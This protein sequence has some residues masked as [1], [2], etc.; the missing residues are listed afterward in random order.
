M[1]GIVEQINFISLLLD[2]LPSHAPGFDKA[3]LQA[4]LENQSQPISYRQLLRYLDDLEQVGWVQREKSGKN[5]LWVRIHR[6]THLLSISRE[7]A[8]ALQ[9]IQHKLRH[10]MPPQLL[11]ALAEEF[12]LAH[13]KLSL[14][15]PHERQWLGKIGEVPSLLTPPEFHE[16]IFG[17]ITEA[18]LEDKWLEANY[19]NKD[20]EENLRRI[21]PLG[22]ASRDGVYYLIGRNPASDETRQFRIDRIISATMTDQPF[23]YPADFKLVDY[24]DDGFFNYPH[25][26]KIKLIARI[27]KLPARHLQDTPL[28]SDQIIE[29]ID[30]NWLRLSATVQDSQR[31]HWW[32]LG[33]GDQIVVESPIELRNEIAR[34]AIQMARNYASAAAGLNQDKE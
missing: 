10:L 1:A 13:D 17:V 3:R 6:G 15:C 9:L 7:R 34:H 18:L 29:Q 16:G 4:W 31:L 30:E 23:T 22:I 8:F 28:A 5:D 27:H 24:M 12:R 25:G 32:I 14:H 19:R 26:G 2:F 20:G 11:Q 21:L 33:F